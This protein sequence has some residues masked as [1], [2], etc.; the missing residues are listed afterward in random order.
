MNQVMPRYASRAATPLRGVSLMRSRFLL[1]SAVL[2]T[3]FL[4][5]CSDDIATTP[6][7]EA[8]KV[9]AAVS[10]GERYSRIV[11]TTPST[12]TYSMTV[13][14]VKQMYSKLIYSSGGYLPGVPYATWT[15]VDPCIAKVTSASPS[16]G[17]VTGIKSGTTKIIASAWGKADTV[18]VTVTGTGNLN[19]SCYTQLWSFNTNDVSFTGTPATS[20]GVKSG[21]T[22]RK[23]VLF[24]PKETW[25]IGRQRSVI[26]ELW[27][28]GGGKL[29]AKGYAN[30]MS[31][32]GSVASIDYRSG[33][34]TTK[35]AGRT[36]LILSLGNMRDTVPL[37]VK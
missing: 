19:S 37:Y 36:K 35:K 26:G 24:A 2:A 14:G 31:T 3:S 28:S 11:I 20:Y 33:L 30:F 7:G 15:S 34:V 8:P 13:G 18:T 9:D 22:L 32:D 6:N 10:T 1:P 16:W 21:E 4:A 5:A 29:N 12:T 23:L 27:Y 25:P 17:K